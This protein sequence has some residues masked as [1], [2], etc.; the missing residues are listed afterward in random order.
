M[1]S[2]T[3]ILATRDGVQITASLVSADGA[4]RAVVLIVPAM[5]VAQ[6]YYRAFAEW[7]AG[8][9]YAAVTFDFRGIGASR[10][11]PM[12]AIRANIFDWAEKDAAAALVFARAF[13][14]GI[15]LYWIGHSLGGQI[16][17]LVPGREA[18]A[19]AITIASG[20]GYWRENTRGLRW[21]VW[22]LWF[23]AV[24]L[25]TR[26]AGY[27]PGKRLRKVGDLPRGVILQWRRWCLDPD[28]AVG[29]EGQAVRARYAAV[30]TPIVSLSFTDDEFMSA[31]N[32]A[33]LHD[34]YVNAPRVMRRFSAAEL[35]LGRIG[36]FG[37]F[38]PACEAVWRTH[39]LPELAT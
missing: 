20:S 2:L 30:T 39:L 26:I 6:T 37:F 31:R 1:I 36:H 4:P 17:P 8:R 14:P 22:W 9:G 10:H 28:Y 29:A 7:L 34:F 13:A 32:I 11:G 18:I 12:K 16:L 25:A 5:G 27:F 33:A 21:R 38:K 15:P 24:P 23:V 3:E 35:G 19:K